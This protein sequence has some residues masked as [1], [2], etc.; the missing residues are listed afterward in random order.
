MKTPIVPAIVA[1]ILNWPVFGDASTLLQDRLEKE[2]HWQ[3]EGLFVLP[4]RPNYFMPMSY[5]PHPNNAPFSPGASL[6]EIETKFQVSVK[7]P[8][9]DHLFKS[10][11]QTVLAYTQVSFW[12]SY[13]KQKS[14]LFR[15]TDYEPELF[16]QLNFDKS[17]GA[18]TNRFNRLGYAHQSNGQSGANSRS[19]NR[20]YAEFVLDTQSSFISF[21]PWYRL[22][23]PAEQDSNPDMWKYYGY[24]ELRAA[25]K[26]FGRHEVSLLFRNNLRIPENKGAIELGWSFPLIRSTK[27]FVQYFNGYGESL[28]DYNVPV[29]RI[30]VGLSFSDWL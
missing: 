17:I 21:K 27:G 3:Q 1:A 2:N 29:S 24:G 28:L 7:V 15:E 26:I 22:A 8:V 30:S 9:A 19:W 11:I 14:S 25:M 12:Q 20:I 13:N 5:N 10:N 23:G 16:L 18:F 4:H 6:Q